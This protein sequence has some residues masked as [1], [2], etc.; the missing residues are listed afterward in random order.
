MKKL[1]LIT[2]VLLFVSFSLTASGSA[3]DLIREL[4]DVDEFHSVKMSGSGTLYITQGGPAKLQVE[5]TKRILDNLE[6]YVDDGTLIVKRKPTFLLSSGTLNVY[7]QMVEV[8]ELDTSGSCEIKG[9]NTIKADNLEIETS[10]SGDVDLSLKTAYLKTK[11]S[12]SSDFKLRGIADNH[13]FKVSGS[14]DLDAFDLVSKNVRIV[15]S[16]S[17]RAR[18]AVSDTLT[19]KL[20]GSSRVFYKGDP[21]KVT[22]EISGSGRVEK[23]E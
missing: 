5:S 8:R 17:G 11:S 19:I 16:G 12:G 2:A 6:T 1:F 10:G 15:I 21:K 4:R 3:S 7:V 13:E 20:S 9:R 22:Q 23:V 18:I 14:G